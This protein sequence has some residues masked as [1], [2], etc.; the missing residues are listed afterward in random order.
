MS[1]T[2]NAAAATPEE[3]DDLADF[4]ADLDKDLK[5]QP[6]NGR[7]QPAK[8]ISWAEPDFVQQWYPAGITLVVNTQICKCG[9]CAQSVEGLFAT[10][11]HRNG[12]TREQRIE[13]GVIPETHLGK[14][15]T[16]KEMLQHIDVCPACFNAAAII[17]AAPTTTQENPQ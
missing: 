3:F 16:I 10:D 15:R 17:T 8:K 14:P 2:A 11:M 12:A 9:C 7:R 5:K 4:M 13:T 6:A 1:A